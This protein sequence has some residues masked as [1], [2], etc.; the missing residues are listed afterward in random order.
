MQGLKMND[1]EDEDVLFINDGEKQKPINLDVFLILTKV[2]CS[3][4]GIPLNVLIAIFIIRFRR[5]H[6]KPRH[7]FLLGIILS[8]LFAFASV[9]IELTYWMAPNDLVCQSFVAVVG[10]P[11]ALLLFNMLLAL[12]DRYVAIKNPMW[13]RKKVTARRVAWA[14]LLG[15]VSISLVLKF[16]YIFGLAPLQCEIR[17]LHN[18]LLGWTRTVLFILCIITNFIVYRQ[19]KTLLKESR[20]LN[21][22]KN[23]SQ[24]FL[25]HKRFNATP[26]SNNSN[27]GNNV[28]VEMIQLAPIETRNILVPNRASVSSSDPS[29][30]AVIQFNSGTLSQMEL[31]A[32]RTLISG[33]TSL[34][35]MACPLI[36]FFL[37]ITFCRFFYNTT[38]ECNSISWLAPY[39]KEFSLIHTVYLP[40]LWLLKNDEFRLVLDKSRSR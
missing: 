4:L 6:S 35:L 22:S 21:S 1:S 33:V 37:V 18:K 38:I 25:Q 3:F 20:M 39:F 26:N 2:A 7:I 12:A 30:G 17:M 11:Y 31:E 19:T 8:N 27:G 36:I 10:L 28:L 9:V 16:I 29:S 24:T 23:T 32:T 14:L 15:W 34:F 5:F 40:L 13:H